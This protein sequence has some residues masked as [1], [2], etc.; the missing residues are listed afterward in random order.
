MLWFS[1]MVLLSIIKR[2][3][4]SNAKFENHIY[5]S[6]TMRPKDTKK[7]YCPSPDPDATDCSGAYDDAVAA[8]TVT[9][10]T[11]SAL[12]TEGVKTAATNAI[13]IYIDK[14]LASRCF[15]GCP[16][17]IN[18]STLATVPD[19]SAVAAACK[20][21]TPIVGT[22]ALTDANCPSDASNTEATCQTAYNDV[23]SAINVT[24]PA[25]WVGTAI[26]TK[27]AAYV[28]A[29]TKAACAATC[30]PVIS[31]VNVGRQYTN[32]LLNLTEKCNP[33]PP[34]PAPPP[35]GDIGLMTF[36]HSLIMIFFL[37]ASLFGFELITYV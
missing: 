14:C 23:V 33:Y 5:D 17:L 12:W 27:I 2:S 21:L 20:P 16:T 13:N 32:L 4:A 35:E 8:A 19:L 11:D 18:V 1:M 29:C 30:R 34:A 28:T 24:T 26:V 37:I 22:A 6:F 7:Y 15:T 25:S 9:D 31:G 3:S 36:R 10:P